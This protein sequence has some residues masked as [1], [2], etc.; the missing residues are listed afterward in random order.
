MAV[1]IENAIVFVKDE[2]AKRGLTVRDEIADLLQ[3]DARGRWE[4]G[5]WFRGPIDG[6]GD[7]AVRAA[8]L[9]RLERYTH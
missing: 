2:A 6:W 1:M 3:E 8:I 4:G 5:V 7:A 9:N